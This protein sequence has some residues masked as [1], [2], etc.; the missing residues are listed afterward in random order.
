MFQEGW[1]HQ[2][3]DEDQELTMRCSNKEAI[4]DRGN[5]SPS[6]KERRERLDGVGS[7]VRREIGDSEKR[8][9]LQEALLERKERKGY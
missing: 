2:E 5:N 3:Q 6:W 7:R 8:P 9:I 1:E 4:G